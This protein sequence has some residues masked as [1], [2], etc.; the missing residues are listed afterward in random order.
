MAEKGT[1]IPV[2]L[3]VADIVTKLAAKKAQ[4]LNL[5]RLSRTQYAEMV[6]RDLAKKEL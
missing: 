3:E 4:S 6:F 2:S 5:P 1:T